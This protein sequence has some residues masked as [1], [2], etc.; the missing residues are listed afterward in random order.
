LTDP[1]RST[2]GRIGAHISWA[3]TVDPT[4]RTSN[5]RKAFADRF[6][7]QAGGDPVRAEHLRKAY[8]LALAA[9][10]AK[11]RAGRKRGVELKQ[12]LAKLTA[13]RA[14]IDAAIDDLGGGA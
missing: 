6:L 7:D 11:A 12:E 8:F 13:A 9:K 4:A 3:N 14:E 5:A 10:R 1:A 2:A